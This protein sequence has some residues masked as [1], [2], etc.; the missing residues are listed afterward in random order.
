MS[1][2]PK[3]GQPSP[4]FGEYPHDF[5]DFIII[6][7]CH[8]GGANDESNWRG[9]MEYFAPAVQLGMTATPKRKDNVDT[10]AYFGDPVYIYSLK[11]D[12]NDGFL[13]PFRVKQIATTL[14]EYVYTPDDQVIEGE[15]EAFKSFFL[16]SEVLHNARTSSSSLKNSGS[17][18]NSNSMNCWAE[19]GV[20]SGCQNV[21]RKG[22]ICLGIRCRSICHTMSTSTPA[23]L[24]LCWTWIILRSSPLTLMNP[25][26]VILHG[27]STIRSILLFVM[28]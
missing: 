18:P 3:D 2:P 25:P 10:Y 5:F 4:Y 20:P 1:G 23:R 28:Q 22:S 11:E 14:D 15:I 16:V 19:I 17:L 27:S 8:R 21:S 12:I 24:F 13:T 7:E 6:D 26:S 9:I